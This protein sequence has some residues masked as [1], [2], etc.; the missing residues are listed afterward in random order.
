MFLR[1]GMLIGVVVV[2]V[3]MVGMI[4]VMVQDRMLVVLI[5][6]GFQYQFWQVVKQGVDKV[7]VDLG[8]D[9]MFEGLDNEM[10]VDKQMDMLVVVLVKKFSVIVLV[11]L[12]SQVVIL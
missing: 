5:L 3:L 12:D 7:G 1:W 11:V 9:V 4:G 8:V 2:L 6:K 10:Q